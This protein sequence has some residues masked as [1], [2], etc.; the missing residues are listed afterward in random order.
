MPISFDGP[1]KRI[2]LPSGTTVLSVKDLYSRWVDW[3]LTGDNSKYL[4]AFSTTGGDDIDQSSGTAIPIYAF[5]VNGWKIRP[6]EANHTLNITSGV[7]LV[8]GGGDPFISTIGTYMVRINYQQPV[9]AIGFNTGGGGGGAT[10]SDIW[11]YSS[12]ALTDSPITAQDKTDIATKVWDKPLS[13]LTTANS[14][15]EWVKSKLLSVAKYLAL[16]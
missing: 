8:S 12:R 2:D 14:V 1:N 3:Y 13:E 5:L 7:L 11:S 16:K 6:Q 9:Q 15:G 10:A 4:P